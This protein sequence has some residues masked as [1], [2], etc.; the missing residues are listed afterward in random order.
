[1][2]DGVKAHP[3]PKVFMNSDVKVENIITVPCLGITPISSLCNFRHGPVTTALNKNSDQMGKKKKKYSH[4][5]SILPQQELHSH[6]SIF[7]N[8][9]CTD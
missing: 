4:Y 2:S 9:S 5:T 3:A 1:M 6:I 8:P 7:P